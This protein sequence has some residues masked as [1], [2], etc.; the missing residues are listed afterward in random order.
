MPEKDVVRVLRTKD[1][2]T[3]VDSMKTW[4]H[5]PITLGHPE[6]FVTPENVRDLARGE[7]STEAEWIDGKM[8]LPLIIK[9]AEAISAV[10]EKKAAE[11]SAGYTCDIDKTGGMHAT[12]GLY[13]AQQKNI[14]I[15]HLALVPAG[16]A[17][18]ECR[19]GD[20]ADTWGASP[21]TVSDHKEDS[22]SDALKPVVLGDKAIN[23]TADAALA[24]ENYTRD[25]NARIAKLEADHK[26]ALETR[27]E[28]IGTLR[29]QVKTLEDGQMTPDRL[30]KLVAERA[31]LENAVRAFDASIKVE[32]VSDEDLRKQVVAKQMGD[33]AVKDASDAE[34]KGMFK[35]IA[36]TVKP[37]DSF[38]DATLPGNKGNGNTVVSDLD[39]MRKKAKEAQDRAAEARANAWKQNAS[40]AN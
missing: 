31:A 6:E 5:A 1:E 36:K 8:K 35:A 24:I 4:P 2:V 33:E 23:V 13:D 7:V 27:D 17:G 16:R 26:S 29:A 10:E 14:R 32:G 40:E 34:I 37:K 15:N 22:M 21:I 18:S 38:L 12:F 3:A 30:S 25:V 20:G 11:L 28:T 19:I 9:D 39:A